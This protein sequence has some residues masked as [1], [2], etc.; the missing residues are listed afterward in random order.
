[1]KVAQDPMEYEIIGS[2]AEAVIY[3]DRDEVV[4]ERVSKSYR[5]PKIDESLRKSRTRREAKILSKLRQIKF[6]APMLASMDDKNMK[7]N[8]E[9]LAGDKLRDVFHEDAVNFSREIGKNIGVLHNNKIIH[10][11]LTTSNMILKKGKIH[12]IDF[13]LSF[14]SEKVEDMAVDLHLL[15]RAMESRHHKFYPKCFDEAVKE[16]LKT[17]EKGE[18]VL[19]RF[20]KVTLRGRNKNKH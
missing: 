6:P 13:G 16:Y 19:E 14:F 12:F 5:H 2:G 3:H 9:F 10:H 7:V 17:A 1:M 11:D 20:R 4:K 18:E 8:M 15:E